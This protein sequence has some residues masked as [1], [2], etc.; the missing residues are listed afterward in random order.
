MSKFK[1]WIDNPSTQIETSE[2]FDVEEQRVR[3]FLSGEKISSKINNTILRQTSLVTAALMLALDV[4]DDI[5]VSSSVD[6][7]AY[8]IVSKWPKLDKWYLHS[9]T[10]GDTSA[11]IPPNSEMQVISKR[12]SAYTDFGQM[13]DEMYANEIPSSQILKCF[14]SQYV[15]ITYLD[16]SLIRLYT[17]RVSSENVLGTADKTQIFGPTETNV[18]I[19]TSI[20]NDIVTEL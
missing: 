16:R 11:A 2:Q 7:V 6:E 1:V 10:V 8:E 17:V 20:T 4:S 18:F 9:L 5:D 14:A 15:G 13:V 19:R 3:G 12:S